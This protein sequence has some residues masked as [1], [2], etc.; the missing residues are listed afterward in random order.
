MKKVMSSASNLF[1]R[2]GGKRLSQ[3]L[4]LFVALALTPSMLLAEDEDHISKV[5]DPTGA[6]LI[7]A[8]N[9]GPFFL[10][11]FHKG[12]T[13][14]QDRQGE[15]AFDPAAV[16]DPSS[17]LNVISSPVSGVWQKT[18]GNTFA[19]TGL[20]MEYHN[21]TTPDA[22]PIT[23]IFQFAKEQFTGRLTDSGDGI[24]IS[25]FVTRFDSNGIKT[26]DFTFNATGVRI[27][28]EVL[29]NTSQSLPI[30]K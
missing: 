11:V 13:L 15:S 6:W 26:S 16:K 7:K 22:D 25:A 23:P 12:G 29:P 19:A 17:E 8:E 24:T 18:G 28:L 21:D 20:D 1:D 30:P 14:T 4:S 27:R 5:H 10:T 2:W 9:G 3:L